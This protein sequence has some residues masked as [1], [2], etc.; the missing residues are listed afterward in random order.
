M[1]NR[2]RAVWVE[3]QLARVDTF[4]VNLFVGLPLL[5]ITRNDI[6]TLEEARLV[7]QEMLDDAADVGYNLYG[8]RPMIYIVTKGIP[9]TVHYENY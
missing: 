6:P 8:R 5:Y 3:E 7:C 2:R 9:Q 1:N 4:T